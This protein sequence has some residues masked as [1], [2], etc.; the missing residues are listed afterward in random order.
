MAALIPVSD[1]QAGAI[2]E[3][4]KTTGT[5]LELVEN[6]VR[7]SV[8]YSVRRRPISRGCLVAIG[9]GGSHPKPCSA[10]G[11]DRRNSEQARRTRCDLRKPVAGYP[12]AP[13][14]C[15]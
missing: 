13:S 10:Q 3:V 5:A 1:E 12:A 4:A 15:R 11:A 8:R 2:R 9:S 6:A 14:G 7:I